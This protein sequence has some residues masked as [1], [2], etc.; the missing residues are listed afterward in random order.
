M[1]TTDG[2]FPYQVCEC[3]VVLRGI[4]D[5]SWKGAKT[6]MA[7]NRFLNTLVEF[8]KDTINEKQV[9]Q[10]HLTPFAQTPLCHLSSLPLQRFFRIPRHCRPRESPVHDAP[11]TFRIDCRATASSLR[12]HYRARESPSHSPRSAGD[13]HILSLQNDRIRE[14]K[15]K[16]PKTQTKT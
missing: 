2:L 10:H 14:P 11:K 15:Q 12:S 5:V 8:E 9:R 1:R 16:P 13:L 3:V 7:D 4:K 6:M